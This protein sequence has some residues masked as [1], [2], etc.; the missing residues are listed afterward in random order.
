[1]ELDNLFANEAHPKCDGCGILKKTLAEHCILETPYEEQREV[2][3]VSDFPKISQG[4]FVPFRPNE[5]GAIMHEVKKH[6]LGFDDVAFTASVKCPILKADMI[7]AVDRKICRQ[8]LVDT[9]LKVKPKLIFV[10]GKLP[11]LM[12]FGKAIKESKIRGSVSQVEFTEDFTSSV[13]QIFHPWQVVSEPKNRY[14]FNLDIAQAIKYSLRGEAKKSDFTFEVCD[15]EEDLVRNL[16][17][18]ML[19]RPI[20]VDLETTGLNFLKDTIHTIALS[21]Y[22]QGKVH[23]IAIPWDHPEDTAPS[24]LKEFRKKIVSAIIE[25]RDVPIIFQGGKFDRRFL[26]L[27]GIRNIV[28]MWDTKIMQHLKNEDIPKS[29]K[30][31]VK[32]YFSDE[33]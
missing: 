9:I 19:G 2:L 7:S 5:Y 26:H 6:G 13:C 25:N 32:Y 29:L 28:R 17:I 30:A 31:L 21:T 14:L 16:P 4:E 24:L 12:V 15:E 10:C 33:I 22:Y 8:H 18:F 11:S 3:F 27:Q 23:T 1:M 20:A